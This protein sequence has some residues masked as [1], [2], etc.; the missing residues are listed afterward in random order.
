MKEIQ[1]TQ[2]KVALVS[3]RCF[4]YI[5][6]WKWHAHFG[7]VWYAERNEGKWPFQKKIKMHRVIMGITDSD[8]KIDHIDGNG[9][10]NQ[11]ENLRVCTHAQNLRNRKKPS[12]NTSGWKG[13]CLI[14]NKY[15]AQ[16]TA[17]GKVIYLGSFLTP[18]DAARAYDKAAKKYHK[19]FAYLNFPEGA[20]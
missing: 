11:D 18:E 4:E 2:G 3:D 16:I 10:N 17:E 20:R 9:L 8:I 5:N 12:N 1:L 14:G 19:E 7:D 13:V 15:Q 6:Q